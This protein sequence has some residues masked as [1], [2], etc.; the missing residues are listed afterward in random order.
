MMRS[1][2]ES[3]HAFEQGKGVLSGEAERKTLVTLTN[4]GITKE[5]L[6]CIVALSR[7]SVRPTHHRASI[8]GPR[9]DL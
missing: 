8:G 4:G 3:R 2:V 6:P 5:Q 7:S 9:V 1:G